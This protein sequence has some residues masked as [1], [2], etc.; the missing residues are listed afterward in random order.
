MLAYVD[1]RY[2][3]LNQPAIGIEDRGY[4]FADGVYEVCG[5]HR[6]RLIDIDAHLA[7]LARSCKRL[8]LR[9]PVSRRA[10]R[11]I[12]RE[13]VRRNRLADGSL[14]IQV[15]RG[16][17]PRTHAPKQSARAVLVATLRPT[18]VRARRRLQAEGAAV[19]T[20]PDNRWAHCDIKTI[21]LLPNVLASQTA[22]RARADE[23][24]FVSAEGL[25]LEGAASTAWIVD[26][27]G[28]V[29]T[30]PDSPKLL[31]GITRARLLA[32][33]RARQ[34]K[35]EERGFSREEALTAREAFLTTSTKSVIPVVRL[36]SHVIQGG[37][38][39]EL[40]ASLKDFDR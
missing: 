25:I 16:C 12:V 33:L 2:V 3:P 15:T 1:G 22:Q 18:D 27:K 6:G 34:I 21:A 37:T 8:R 14:Y 13:L 31:P 10:L 39:G 17:A 9:C 4:Q 19:I 36:D 26:A 35:V 11:L 23:A 30:H 5:L 20:L 32:Y 29:R 40:S 24:W 38:I 28:I 7:R